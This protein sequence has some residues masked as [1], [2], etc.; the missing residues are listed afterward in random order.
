MTTFI[1]KVDDFSCTDLFRMTKKVS[2]QAE[3]VNGRFYHVYNRTVGKELLFA[4]D[5]NFRF[6]LQQY[7]KYTQPYV[8]TWAYCL[9][10]DHFHFLIRIKENEDSK[11]NSEVGI[12]HLFISR[13][14]RKFFQSY[15]MA[16]NKQESRHG[17]LLCTPFKRIE[18]GSDE[19]LKRLIYYIHANPQKHGYVPDFRIWKWS[20]YMAMNSNANTLL[21]R[22]AVLELFDGPASF[23]KEHEEFR[24]ALV[25]ET[26]QLEE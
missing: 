25:N 5:E 21:Q 4:T 19:Y 15:V 2:H 16:F 10:P 3:F 17:T 12:D 23:L 14:F 18:V 11:L 22:A 24:D 13:Q 9:L 26:L 1:W 6:F 20:S 7:T 8:E